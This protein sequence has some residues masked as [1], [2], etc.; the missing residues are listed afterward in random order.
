M[1]ISSVSNMIYHK[2][3]HGATFYTLNGKN[4]NIM[5]DL[6]FNHFYLFFFF[7][8]VFLVIFCLHVNIVNLLYLLTNLCRTEFTPQ[9]FNKHK[10]CG[11]FHLH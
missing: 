6:F 9:I 8:F 7:F 1:C 11:D 3:S 5:L 2:F 4:V 10:W